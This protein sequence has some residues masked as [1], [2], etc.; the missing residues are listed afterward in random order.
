MEHS[1]LFFSLSFVCVL[2]S[3]SLIPIHTQSSSYNPFGIC[4]EGVSLLLLFLQEVEELLLRGAVENID[5][6][7]V[8][9]VQESKERFDLQSIL[10]GQPKSRTPLMH[11]VG[12]G[13]SL[14]KEREYGKK[15]RR[16]LGMASLVEAGENRGTM[17]YSRWGK[18]IR[19]SGAEAGQDKCK[20]Y[21]GL[22]REN[23]ALANHGF[24][25]GKCR[26]GFV[27]QTT[28]ISTIFFFSLFYS[29]FTVFVYL[30]FS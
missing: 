2:P 25:L 17:D 15:C 21:V 16:A 22:G 11:E 19:T 6:R 3:T 9:V 7:W 30:F 24:D 13:K 1:Q 28:N 29:I 23:C 26:V 8:C 14:Q 18:R 20:G 12:L 4:R 27:N 5:N 10:P